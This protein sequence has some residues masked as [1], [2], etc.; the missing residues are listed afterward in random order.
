MRQFV[1]R[2]FTSLQLGKQRSDTYVPRK[3]RQNVR[4]ARAAIPF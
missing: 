2:Q 3:D 1:H 4:P